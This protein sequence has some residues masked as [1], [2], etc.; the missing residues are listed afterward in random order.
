[1]IGLAFVVAGA[2][3]VLGFAVAVALRYAPTVQ[4]QLAGLALVSVCVPLAAV[5]AS[6]WVMFHMGADRKILAVAA[7]S[8]TAAV[9]TG[10]VT[11]HVRRL[12]EKVERDPARPD[13]LKTVWG[14]GY[15]LDP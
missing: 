5:L 6:G 14:V 11:V 7:G 10:T 1:M 15:R 3:L 9:D 12:R 8:A 13:H 2:S 4:L